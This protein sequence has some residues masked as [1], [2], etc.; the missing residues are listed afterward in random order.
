MTALALPLLLAVAPGPE[1]EPSRLVLHLAVADAPAAIDQPSF[2]FELLPKQTRAA[3]DQARDEELARSI[4]TRRRLLE[5][6]QGFGIATVAL[7]A[8][9]VVVGQLSYSDKFGGANTGQYELAHGW[10]EAGATL[11]FVTSGLLALLAPVPFEK[12]PGGF[13]AVTIHKWSMLVATLG[14]A[15]EIVLGIITV[16]REGHLNQ[17]AVA[18]AHLVTGYVTTAAVATGVGALLLP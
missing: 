13:D 8:A 11:T 12:K 5:L 7:L 9:T 18:E 16:A 14:Y 1:A 6:H 2:D 17:Q 3:E 10:L 15:A 4:V